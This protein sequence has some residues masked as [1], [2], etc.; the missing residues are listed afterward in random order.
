MAELPPRLKD[1]NN[2]AKFI[3]MV[4]AFDFF[5]VFFWII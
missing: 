4:V 5:F 2:D 1:P 3:I